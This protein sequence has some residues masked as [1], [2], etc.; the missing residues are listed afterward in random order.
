MQDHDFI[1][2][3]EVRKNINLEGYRPECSLRKDLSSGGVGFLIK[4]ELKD[5]VEI[6]RN[7]LNADYIICRLKKEFFKQPKDI[8]LVNAYARPINSSKANVDKSGSDI[9]D[10]VETIINDLREQGEIILFNSRIGEQTGMIKDDSNNFLPVPEDLETDSYQQRCSQDKKTNTYSKQF[11]NLVTHN[12]LIILNGRTLGD[13][14]GHFTSIQP[15]GCSVVDYFAVSK[16]IQSNVNYLRVKELTEYSDH[17]PLS[18]ELHSRQLEII[19]KNSL[20]DMYKSAPGRFIFNEENKST[21]YESQ[22]STESIQIIKS[23]NEM[24]D[25]IIKGN[26]NDRKYMQDSV[27][28]LNNNFTEHVCN[29][30]STSFKQTKII[31]KKK[32]PN[33]PWFN[34]QARSAKRELRKATKS[35]SDFPTS[36]FLRQN[37]YCVKSEYKKILS[38][39]KTRYFEKLNKDIEDGKILNWQAFKKL[40]KQKETKTAYDSLDMNN[41]E[42]FFQELYSDKHSTVTDDQKEE[43]LKKAD[44][45]NYASLHPQ[46]L[47]DPFTMT[48]IASAIKSLKSGKASSIDMIS[49]EILKNLDAQHYEFLTKLFNLCLECNIYLWNKS[50]IAPL[51]KKKVSFPTLTTTEQLLLVVQ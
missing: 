8:Y 40:K 9:M 37:F 10:E 29:I 7:K 28:E 17:K 18:M 15:Q 5:G 50:V 4:N 34:W 22:K 6:I 33:N 27:K 35:T 26:L 20:E 13:F 47:N 16:S 49:N 21:F 43:Y 32:K 42:A 24:H 12:Q 36:D 39:S 46:S 30:A 31:T 23:L 19:P 45:I 51:L 11:L 3:Q 14:K 44:D 41:F 2:L 38:K 25:V 1:C 48:E